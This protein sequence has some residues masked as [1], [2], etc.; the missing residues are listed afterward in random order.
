MNNNIPV[1]TFELLPF[2]QTLTQVLY[3]INHSSNIG[4]LDVDFAASLT[5]TLVN[6]YIT[7]L[8]YEQQQLL[9]TH[10]ILFDKWL[11]HKSIHKTASTSYNKLIDF[12]PTQQNVLN[13][14]SSNS[15]PKHQQQQYSTNVPKLDIWTSS[16]NHNAARHTF[17]SK[18]ICINGKREII[19]R[20]KKRSH[21]DGTSVVT[22]Y[23]S[24][25]DRNNT[26]FQIRHNLRTDVAEFNGVSLF[27]YSCFVTVNK[28][29]DVLQHFVPLPVPQQQT[30]TNLRQCI[31]YPNS[32]FTDS[33]KNA[34]S[35]RRTNTQ[36]GKF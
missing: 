20:D 26:Y 28:L 6:T 7:K 15:N 1:T 30:E 2:L 9:R 3:E 35:C 10:R 24:C 36:N 31:T 22:Y 11:Q 5:T 13:L 29:D 19:E 32:N 12:N 34:N 25:A 8:P 18:F 23:C 4:A 27:K 14:H 21:K 33:A 16:N 17:Q